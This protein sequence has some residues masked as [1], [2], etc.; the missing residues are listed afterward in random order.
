MFYAILM[1]GILHS[2]LNK[3]RSELNRSSGP[4]LWLGLGLS[5]YALINYTVVVFSSKRIILILLKS[6]DGVWDEQKNLKIY[7]VVEYN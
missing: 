6:M 4:L 1:Q 5:S 2:E 7:T 3:C